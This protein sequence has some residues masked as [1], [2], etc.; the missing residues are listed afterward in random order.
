MRAANKWKGTKKLFQ[1][2]Y[3]LR[4]LVEGILSIDYLLSRI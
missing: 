2:M 3:V 4:R 1:K